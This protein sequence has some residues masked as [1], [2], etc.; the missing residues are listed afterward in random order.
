MKKVSWLR[1]PFRSNFRLRL[2]KDCEIKFYFVL[3]ASWRIWIGDLQ[4]I[5]NNSKNRS[6][7][8]ALF[9]MDPTFKSVLL[10]WTLD[11]AKYYYGLPMDPTFDVNTNTYEVK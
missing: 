11:P 5:V 10:F 9:S 8:V 7:I 1:I 6:D 2:E 4:F 3:D